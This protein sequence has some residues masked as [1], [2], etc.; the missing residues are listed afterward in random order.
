MT[1]YHLI[2]GNSA[3]AGKVIMTDSFANVQRRRK[4]LQQSCTKKGF[5]KRGPFWVIK[6]N[7]EETVKFSQKPHT[8]WDNYNRPGPRRVR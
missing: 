2:E 3:Q 1:L 5:Y 8:K 4:T 6:A 7:E